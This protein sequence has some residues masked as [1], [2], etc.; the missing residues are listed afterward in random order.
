MSDLIFLV[1]S[2]E[3]LSSSSLFVSPAGWALMALVSWMTCGKIQKYKVCRPYG[4][5]EG[6]NKKRPSTQTATNT[7]ESYLAVTGGINKK[8]PSTISMMV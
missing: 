8:R 6:I 1:S 4:V 7:Y 5:T 3:V 2:G